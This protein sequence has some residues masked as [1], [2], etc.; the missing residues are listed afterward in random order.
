MR[1]PVLHSGAKTVWAPASAVVVGNK[2]YFGGLLGRALYEVT[3]GE[4]GVTNL[5]EYFKNEFGRIRTVRMGPDGFLYLTTSNRD[6]RGDPVAEDD[7]IIR[8]DPKSLD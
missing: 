8:V 4:N 2:L 5:K 1:T 3:L 6:G 7:R